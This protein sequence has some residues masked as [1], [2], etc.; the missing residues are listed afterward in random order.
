[1]DRSQ[2]GGI[3]NSSPLSSAYFFSHYLLPIHPSQFIGASV[4]S[5]LPALP[6]ELL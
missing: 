5:E 6:F 4:D 3:D 2:A 1:M